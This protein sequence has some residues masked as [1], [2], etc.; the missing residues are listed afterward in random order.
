ME[1]HLETDP[2]R[3][4]AGEVGMYQIMPAR[5]EAEGWSA[6]RLKEPEFNAW[7]GTRLLA[8]YYREEG[9]WARAAAKY[10]AGPVVFESKYSKNMWTYINW[11]SNS[12]SGYANYFSR[13][14]S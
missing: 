7:L 11:Y 13:Y 8:R 14:A 10:V 3:G 5:C 2:P 1:S 9:D 4:A 6:E 12:V